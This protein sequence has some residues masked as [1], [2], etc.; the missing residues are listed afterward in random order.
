MVALIGVWVIPRLSKP[1][2][3]QNI[4]LRAAP[5]DRASTYLFS[6]FS[7][8]STLF[9]PKPLRPSTVEICVINIESEMYLW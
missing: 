7:V 3:G 6:A 2:V 8:H 1:V 5:V 4:A 9:F